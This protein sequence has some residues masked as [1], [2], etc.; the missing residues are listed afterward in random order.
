MIRN[1]YNQVPQLTQD[2]NGKVINSQLDTINESQE[3]KRAKGKFMTHNPIS[4][5]TTCTFVAFY[6]NLNFL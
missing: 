5:S 6:A 1:R 2:T 4:D 3:V